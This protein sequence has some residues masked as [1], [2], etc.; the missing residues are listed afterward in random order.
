MWNPE[1]SIT[2]ADALLAEKNGTLESL[3]IIKDEDCFY[4][5]M[6]FSWRKDEELFLSTTRTRKKPR[7]FK[8]LDRLIDYIEA[9]F[10][11]A[12]SVEIVIRR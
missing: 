3:R 5:L 12:N 2:E 10:S 7:K 1:Q 6:K 9:S 4:L 11:C 8:N